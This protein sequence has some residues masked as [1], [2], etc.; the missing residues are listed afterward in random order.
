MNVAELIA[1][2]RELPQGA[3]VVMATKETWKT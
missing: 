3:R 2:L 1:K